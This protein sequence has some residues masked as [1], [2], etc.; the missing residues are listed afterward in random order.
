MENFNDTIFA[1]LLPSL[2]Q[3]TAVMAHLKSKRVSPEQFL[4]YQFDKELHKAEIAGY[5]VTAVL[6]LVLV[7]LGYVGAKDAVEVTNPS[8]GRSLACLDF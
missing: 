2:K 7:G 5:F 8:G 3:Q 6:I 4:V 1:P